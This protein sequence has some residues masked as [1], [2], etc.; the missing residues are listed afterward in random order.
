[1]GNGRVDDDL[2]VKSLI[3]KR[4]GNSLYIINIMKSIEPRSI[5]RDIVVTDKDD[6]ELKQ[7]S[8]KILFL[9]CYFN[10]VLVTFLASLYEVGNINQLIK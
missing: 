6:E 10:K 8:A 3:D 9:I 2:K 4:L 1:M 5:D 7:N